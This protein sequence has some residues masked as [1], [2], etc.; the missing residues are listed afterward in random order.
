MTSTSNP[1]I[2]KVPIANY[3][4]DKLPPKDG[5]NTTD[6]ITVTGPDYTRIIIPAGVKYSSN[7]STNYQ[8]TFTG[9]D[10]GSKTFTI[11][12]PPG[13]TDVTTLNSNNLSGTKYSKIFLTS[14][15]IYYKIGSIFNY[16]YTSSDTS[17]ATIKLGPIDITTSQSGTS[18]VEENKK[19]TPEQFEKVLKEKA[20]AAGEQVASSVEKV[21]YENFNNTFLNLIYT[22]LKDFLVIVVIWLIVISIGLW[23]TVDKDLIY[24]VDVSKYPY[25]YNDGENIN[26]L[27]SFT[28]NDSGVFCGKMDSN[29]ISKI[30]STLRDKLQKDPKLREKMEF[31]NPSMSD[32]SH[33]N[34]YFTAQLIQK[35]CSK[36]GN[37]SD[38]LSVFVYWLSYLLFT[39]GLYQHYVLNGFHSILNGIMRMA[40]GIFSSEGYSA[41]ILIAVIIY[42]I[43]KV[44][45]PTFDMVQKMILKK[46]TINK[47]VID[48]PENIFIY[49]GMNA[50]S[51][52]LFVALPLFFILFFVGLLGHITSILRIIFE[53]NSVECAFLSIIALTATVSSFFQVLNF[54][55]SR[56]FGKFT[57][58][59]VEAQ[60]KSLLNFSSLYKVISN[61]A[62]VGIPL[63]LALY[64]S[65]M[66]VFRIITTSFYL[67]KGKIELLKN[68]SPAIILLL[69]YYLFIHVKNMLGV[70]QSYITLCVIGFFGF[71]FIT[72]K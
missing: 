69:F 67:F 16:N 36:T 59:D 9:P 22:I 40:S 63:A 65:F 58:D 47:D 61:G 35:S 53:S 27:S 11:E 13:T 3:N 12:F 8:S 49:A 33:K 41:S 55:I 39:Q 20:M 15:N 5:E 45:Q 25:T 32:I 26:N 56:G 19:Y 66:I 17:T 46:K 21:V 38:A 37:Y 2:F 50:I 23:G 62:G 6:N 42:G 54:M 1:V 24:P 34:L 10:D 31:I 52:G 28:P 44:I 30:S 70:V 71:Y 68:L 57:L 51:L 60:I 43:M 14:S 64:S 72:K 48:K 18:A 29:E 7:A 4:M